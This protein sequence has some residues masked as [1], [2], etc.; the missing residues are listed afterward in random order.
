MTSKQYKDAEAAAA[1]AKDSPHVETIAAAAAAASS[2]SS[3]PL[4]PVGVVVATDGKFDCTEL[5]NAIVKALAEE[6]I[7][8]AFVMQVEDPMLLPYAAQQLGRSYQVVLAAAVM[9]NDSFGHN[10]AFVQTLTSALLHAGIANGLH[11]VP[12]VICHESLLE[13]RA[14][15]PKKALQWAKST[16]SLLRLRGKGDVES[17]FSPFAYAEPVIAAPPVIIT[18]ENHSVN[19]LMADFRASLFA[20]GATGVFGLA[21]KFR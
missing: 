14:L 12:A 3:A 2:S 9:S 4:P 15:L 21:R 8:N 19:H 5:V 18:A 20:H 17:P 10:V 7:R 11:I 16:S 13:T 1:V 6:G